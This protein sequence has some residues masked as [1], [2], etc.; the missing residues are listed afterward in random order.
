MHLIQYCMLHDLAFGW[1]MKFPKVGD[2]DKSSLAIEN[3][4]H[5]ALLWT[6]NFVKPGIFVKVYKI[7]T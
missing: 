2:I 3:N 5:D 6:I 4:K 1:E 7:K